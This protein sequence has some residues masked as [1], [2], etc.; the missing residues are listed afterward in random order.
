MTSA[1]VVIICPEICTRFFKPVTPFGS[2]IR[3]LFSS[4]VGDLH[5]GDLSKGHLEEAGR[6]C[7][8]FLLLT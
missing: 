2:F 3:D 6:K 7:V 4:V 5:L 8:F 1:E